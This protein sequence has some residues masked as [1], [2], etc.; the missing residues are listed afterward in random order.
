MVLR[1]LCWVYT[2]QVG[3]HGAAKVKCLSIVANDN[4]GRV[5]IVQFIEGSTCRKGLNQGGDVSLRIFK[6]LLD[7][8]QLTGCD[9]GFVSLDV[10]NYVKV[11]L[12]QRA[13]GFVATVRAALVVGACHDK[14]AA[15]ARHLI[16]YSLV[17]SGHIHMVEHFSDALVN[18]LDNGL[19][20]KNSKGFAW[21]A[22]G[23]VAGWYEC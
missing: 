5:G 21:E 19:A 2:S 1:P 4:L 18:V 17:V 13:E 10:H 20:I 23:S 16:C 8:F 9:E 22:G 7:T 14:L 12:A 15:K 6:L 11:F 3:N